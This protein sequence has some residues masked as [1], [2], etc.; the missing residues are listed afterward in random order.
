MEAQEVRLQAG[1]ASG[2][3]APEEPQR[4]GDG[5]AEPCD[6]DAMAADEILFLDGAED[7]DHSAVVARAK[8]RRLLPGAAQS[9]DVF[10]L[11]LSGYRDTWVNRMPVDVVGRLAS[12][13][14]TDS[15]MHLFDGLIY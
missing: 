1:S 15:H 11:M 5:N 2:I 14:S 12:T 13:P 7:A 10:R 4:D 9:A 8:R 6:E 3:G